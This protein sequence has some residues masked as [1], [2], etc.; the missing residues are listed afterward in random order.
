MSQSA[1]SDLPWRSGDELSA[2]RREDRR[3]G[4]SRERREAGERSEKRE[5]GDKEGS[6][7]RKRK[8]GGAGGGD[9]GDSRR[10]GVGHRHGR[11]SGGGGGEKK[12]RTQTD[13]PSPDQTPANKGNDRTIMQFFGP[14]G[15]G[16]AGGES[17][18][19]SLPTPQAE[20]L[21]GTR[22]GSTGETFKALGGDAVLGER[23]RQKLREMEV[24][25]RKRESALEAR[26]KTLHEKE[27]QL[28][29]RCVCVYARCSSF[30]GLA[31]HVCRTCVRAF[32]VCWVRKD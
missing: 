1:P 25:I 26:T 28:A 3:E 32:S 21:G 13:C 2:N 5:R 31:E 16:M 30:T 11:S 24:E 12:S 10:R 9:A 20:L 18:A 22:A 7:R 17:A 14:R 27:A 23:Q 6:S 19:A 8:H 4:P 15:G 29:K